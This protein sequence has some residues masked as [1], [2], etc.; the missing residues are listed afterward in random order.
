MELSRESRA[1]RESCAAFKRGADPDNV[2]TML[3]SKFLLTPEEKGRATQGA[4]NAHQQ[5][6]VVFESLERR[7]SAD[8][9]VFNQLVQVL[10]E[11]PA[12]A[13]VGRKMQ[14][15]SGGWCSCCEIRPWLNVKV[16]CNEHILYDVMVV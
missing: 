14:G 7:V 13:A 5:L 2:I 16:R 6:D 1:L 10:L 3:Y 11:E 9:T 4:L 12:L 15:E 8:P